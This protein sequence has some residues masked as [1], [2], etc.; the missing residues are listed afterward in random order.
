MDFFLSQ[1]NGIEIPPFVFKI[2]KFKTLKKERLWILRRVYMRV[3]YRYFILDIN[4][5]KIML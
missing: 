3:Q 1:S 4:P 2:T 5:Q